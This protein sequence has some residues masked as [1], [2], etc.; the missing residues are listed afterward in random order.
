MCFEMRHGKTVKFYISK[1][2][3]TKK[4]NHSVCL[5]TFT[6]NFCAVSENITGLKAL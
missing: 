4:A 6:T 1:G 2:E 5:V 3:G